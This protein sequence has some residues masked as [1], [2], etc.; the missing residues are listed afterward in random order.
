VKVAELA[1]FNSAAEGLV[2]VRVL[3]IPRYEWPIVRVTRKKG[4]FARGEIFD[5]YPPDLVPRSTN[6]A[7]TE[8]K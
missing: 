3:R 4:R 8:Q 6:D 1:Y 5:V 7:A 2:P